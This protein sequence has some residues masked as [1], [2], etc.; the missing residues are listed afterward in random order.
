MPPKRSLRILLYGNIVGAHHCSQTLI[1]FLLDSGCVISLLCPNFY[2]R[3]EI[4]QSYFLRKFLKGIQLAE[5]LTKAAFADV[6]YLLPLNTHLVEKAA[7]VSRVLD[8]ILIVEVYIS[9]Y[10]TFVNDRK[11]YEEGSKKAYNALYN[12]RLALTKPDYIISTS[13]REPASWAEK[14]SIKLV[15]DKVFVAPNFSNSELV[16][17]RDFMHDSILKIC[18]SGTFIPIHGLDKI[19]LAMKLCKEREVQFTCNLFGVDNPFFDVYL[20]KIQVYELES[21]VFL[22]KDLKFYDDTLPQ[23]LI[24]NCDLA[25]GIFGNTDKA[26]N[27]VPNKLIEALGMGIP[28]LTMDAP[29]LREFFNPETDFWTCEPFPESIA[30]MIMAIAKGTAHSVDW[31][32]TRQK[33]L[34]QFSVAQYQQVVNEILN[35]VGLKLKNDTRKVILSQQQL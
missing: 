30:E 14:L 8:K 27:C 11:N 5:L 19:L 7:W 32:Q 21:H 20:K 10:E 3:R 4:K 25:L 2:S 35:R 16:H 34:S 31:H 22:R 12:D 28:T 17:Q 15:K 23:Y 24:E 13:N 33:V 1:K 18:W 9:L 6:I 29:G 26:L